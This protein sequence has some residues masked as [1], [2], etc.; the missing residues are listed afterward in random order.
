MCGKV[1]R[2]ENFAEDHE[3]EQLVQTFDGRAGIRWA[4]YEID[5]GQAQWLLGHL[6]HVE[7]QLREIAEE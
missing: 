1:S 2:E 6:P 3:L 5:P 7:D 4:T